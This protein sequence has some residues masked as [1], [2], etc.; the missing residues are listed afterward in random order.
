MTII[1]PAARPVKALKKRLPVLDC[2]QAT[3][4]ARAAHRGAGRP[5]GARLAIPARLDL[6]ARQHLE[7]LAQLR[8]RLPD[9]YGDL[10][11]FYRRDPAAPEGTRPESRPD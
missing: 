7:Q 11:K 8:Q 4:E 5:R 3:R 1:E 6:V 2:R 10:K 9:R